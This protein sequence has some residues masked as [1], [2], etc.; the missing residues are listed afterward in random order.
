MSKVQGLG[1]GVQT[2]PSNMLKPFP[3]YRALGLVSV[4]WTSM[5]QKKLVA[6]YRLV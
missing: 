3:G 4:V 1:A 2:I 5:C 6:Y